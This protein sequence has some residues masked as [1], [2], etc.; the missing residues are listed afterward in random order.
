MLDLPTAAAAL[1]GMPSIL[2]VTA[3]RSP[4]TSTSRTEF[5]ASAST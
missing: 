4:D 2:T 5:S 3:G 1:A